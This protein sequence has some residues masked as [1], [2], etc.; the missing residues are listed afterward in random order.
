[1]K[2]NEGSK[3]SGDNGNETTGNQEAGRQ[4]EPERRDRGLKCILNGPKPLPMVEASLEIQTANATTAILTAIEELPPRL[5][6][7]AFQN[8]QRIIEAARRER[9]EEN[10]IQPAQS[11]APWTQQT[12]EAKK[13]V[14]Q[15]GGRRHWWKR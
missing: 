5:A 4:P 1:M 14:N 2:P 12:I 8:A 7:V 15:N 3:N 10:I 11:I 6:V 9:G 13:A